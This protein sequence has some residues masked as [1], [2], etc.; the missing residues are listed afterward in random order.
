MFQP[1]STVSTS[2]GGLDA[3]WVCSDCY[4][5]FL[6]S[7]LPLPVTANVVSSW[8]ILVTLIEETIRSTEMSVLTRATW[9]LIPGDGILHSHGCEN[10]RSY[11]FVTV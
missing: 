10:L 7:V 1:R 8:P 6:R 9:R 4:V 3:H 11:E 5:L 2:I